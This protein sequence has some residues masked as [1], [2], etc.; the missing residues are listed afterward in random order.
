MQRDTS[1]FKNSI[2]IPIL[3]AE[4]ASE[5]GWNEFVSSFLQ[6]TNGNLKEANRLAE[7]AML[8]SLDL[9]KAQVVKQ[10]MADIALKEATDKKI[11]GLEGKDCVTQPYMDIY[12]KNIA[13]KVNGYVYYLD[14]TIPEEY[15]NALEL[16]E[17]KIQ[18]SNDRDV[19]GVFD[20]LSLRQRLIID[21]WRDVNIAF[22]TTLQDNADYMLYSGGQ[23]NP[24]GFFTSNQGLLRNILKELKAN[25]ENS[26]LIKL[27]RKN[28]IDISTES[29]SKEVIQ[30]YDF[31][32][33][34]E[35]EHIK[36]II[37]TLTSQSKK[38]FDNVKN[39]TD[40][41]ERMAI[42]KLY[43]QVLAIHREIEDTKEYGKP[44]PVKKSNH[45]IFD[46][47]GKFG[48]MVASY[49]RDEISAFL[50]LREQEVAPKKP[51][52]SI[53]E[54]KSMQV[55]IVALH[56]QVRGE[57]YEMAQYLT[58]GKFHHNEKKFEAIDHIVRKQ[59]AK[60][61][62]EQNIKE[63]IAYFAHSYKGTE[64]KDNIKAVNLE[65]EF[66]KIKNQFISHYPHVTD[67]KSQDAYALAILVQ[68]YGLER[69]KIKAD[70]LLEEFSTAIIDPLMVAHKNHHVGPNAPTEVASE[71]TRLLSIHS[72]GIRAFRG[73]IKALQN[74][75]FEINSISDMGP[76]KQKVE[77]EFKKANLKGYDGLNLTFA[78]MPKIWT[79]EIFNC[80]EKAGININDND[81]LQYAN[82]LD[83]VHRNPIV[84][85]LVKVLDFEKGIF[86][87][88]FAEQNHRS[89][90][91][92]PHQNKYLNYTQKI[93]AMQQEDLSSC[94]TNVK[95]HGMNKKTAS[96]S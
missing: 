94:L 82:N 42:S 72:G 51:Q 88:I 52:I 23:D 95:Y 6:K 15:A 73:T 38:L 41:Q 74:Q 92:I 57:V 20:S 29:I 89:L 12:A 62:F 65:T 64:W 83:K 43:F 4:L 27:L 1:I 81:T 2:A 60:I 49:I 85:G 56:K 58:D 37:S 93:M 84:E 33:L 77:E 61:Y 36:E 7:N 34:I 78:N 91:T 13:D 14:P 24:I 18:L 48:A 30:G 80:F 16:I 47:I 39:V 59:I 90:E 44:H 63:A 10:L 53:R 17:P 87:I 55:E 75:G 21:F 25:K 22:Y 3:P 31:P 40:E 28:S 35:N 79:D 66:K 9:L 19:I 5:K 67:E 11:I 69:C 46:V 70:G 32:D 8:K 71:E 76:Y 45:G 26:P 86:R 68:T 54:C 50:A 96:R